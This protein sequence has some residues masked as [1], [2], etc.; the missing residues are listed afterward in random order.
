M[1]KMIMISIVLFAS[2]IL[3]ACNSKLNVSKV[4]EDSLDKEIKQL[5]VNQGFENYVNLV[6]K[7]ESA[8]YVV[9]NSGKGVDLVAERDGDTL[10]LQI[11]DKS[12][13]KSIVIYHHIFKISLDKNYDKIKIYRNEKEIEFDTAIH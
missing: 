1:R 8:K 3:A 7:G 12:P 6:D 2:C 5:V 10:K 4:K 13:N 11:T 9:V